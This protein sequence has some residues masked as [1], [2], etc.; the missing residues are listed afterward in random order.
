MNTLD[1]R[2]HSCRFSRDKSGQRTN[3]GCRC[4]K[5][6]PEELRMKIHATFHVLE[7]QVGRLTEALKKIDA[8]RKRLPDPD[9]AEQKNT[10]S[11]IAEI[12]QAALSEKKEGV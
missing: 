8:M 3:G 9:F 10:A 6:V 2:D 1:C 4:L 7:L 12:I 5:T 11:G